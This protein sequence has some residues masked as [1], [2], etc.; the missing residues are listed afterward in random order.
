MALKFPNGTQ[1]GISTAIAAA[2]ATSGV[3][4][5]NPAVASGITTGSIAEGDVLV[6]QS[7]DPL[8]NN[9][10]T[11]AGTVTTGATDTAQLAGLDTSDTDIYDFTGDTTTL[12]I[13][14]GFVNFTQQGDPSTSGG[15]QQFWNGTYLE[16]PTGQQISVP[17]FKNAKV[18]TLPLYFDPSLPW[19]AAAKKADIKKQPVV[20][21]AALPDGDII[22]RYGYLSFDADP[23]MNANTPMGNV[24]T[25]TSLG[26]S[27][28][29][30]A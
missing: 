15:E 4:A 2:L 17:T 16:D 7:T 14:S 8:I 9:L 25:F 23:S 19:Y 30:A 21:R 26:A 20:F 18:L 24:V 5:A 12:A 6:I 27:T 22:Y 29:V 1:F 3:S 13:A 10:A 28:L 11:E